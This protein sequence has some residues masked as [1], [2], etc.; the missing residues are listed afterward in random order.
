[1]RVTPVITGSFKLD[2]G[3]MFGVVPKSIWSK[4]YPCDENNMCSWVMRSLLVE[5]GDRKMIVDT[6]IGNKQSEKWQS[7]FY[8]SGGNVLTNLNANLID[9]LEITDVFITH[10]H[11]DHVGGALIKN[12]LGE[13]ELTF[14]NAT[15]WICDK[16]YNWAI[17]PNPREKPS[18]LQENFIPLVNRNV[19]KWLHYEKDGYFF[20]NGIYINFFNGHTDALMAL[21][22]VTDNQVYFYPSDLLPSHCHIGS[23]YVM[24]YDVRPLITMEEK[25]SFLSDVYQNKGAIIFEHDSL[26]EAATIDCVRGQTYQTK[27]VC[28]S[29]C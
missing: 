18:F 28:I 8:P 15:Y 23:S 16:H 21:K 19:V 6:G 10:L 4:K 17:D 29:D 26:V 1:M 2:G 3:A 25:E 14:P 13:T 20:D 9:P 11:F 7:F 12:Q 22:F 27:E 24:A 5:W